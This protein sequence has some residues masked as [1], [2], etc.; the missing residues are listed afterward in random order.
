M[1]S[2]AKTDNTKKEDK[3][4]DGEGS[5]DSSESISGGGCV[6]GFDGGMAAGEIL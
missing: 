1:A 4:D 5:D 6:C 2:K 3:L